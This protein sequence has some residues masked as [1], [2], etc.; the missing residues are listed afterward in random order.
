MAKVDAPLLSFGARGTIAGVQT[1]SSWRG[2]AYARQR[3]TPANPQTTEQTKTRSVFSWLTQVWKLSQSLSQEPWTAASAGNPFTNR[4]L[5]ISL[6]LA[7]LRDSTTLAPYIGSPGALGGLAPAGASASASGGTLTVT[8]TAPTL[9][10]GWSIQS[11]V[12]MAIVEQDP[13]VGVLYSSKAAEDVSTPFAPAISGLTPGTYRWSAWFTFLR[14][15]QKI[16]YGPSLS[17]QSPV[18]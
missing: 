6:N 9:P 17:G 15:D 14:P 4:N 7:A 5:Y 2:I 13:H 12:A 11:G 8:L 18:A 1:Y 10:A 16:A 3:V